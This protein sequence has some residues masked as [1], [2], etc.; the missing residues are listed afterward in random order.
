MG[1][2]KEKILNIPFLGYII[3]MSYKILKLLFEKIIILTN[4]V[5]QRKIVVCNF[6]GKGYGDNPKYIVEEIIHQGLDYDIVWLVDNV[7]KYIGSFPKEVRLIEYGS[8]KGIYELA[9]A[10]FWIDNCRKYFYTAKRKGQYYIQTWHGGI[11]IKLIEKEA[12]DALD[13]EYI[14]IAKNDSKMIDLLVSNS[15][16]CTEMYQKSF[17]YDGEILE[18][19]SPRVDILFNGSEK[20]K[21]KIYDQYQLDDDTNILLYA[22]TFRNAMDLS[23][24]SLDYNRCLEKLENKFGGKWVIFVR[25]HPNISHLANEIDCSEKIINVT[26]YPDMQELL[27]VSSILV[28]DFSASI[29]EFSFIKK[30]IFIFATDYEDYIKERGFKISFDTLPFRINKSNEELFEDINMFNKK[31]YELQLEE[32]HKYF[33]VYENGQASK[34]VVD[35]IKVIY[36]GG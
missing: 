23:V 12:G 16:W 24:Y 36:N 34:V 9:T 8:L 18:C 35:K 2:I 10:K 29:F 22:P 1:T 31:E 26:D 28:S 21:N 3:A 32:M 30:P 19:G 27:S 33:G 4:K 14:N 15:R 13:E 11:G 5:D 20:I 17:W 7:S 25:L 6:S